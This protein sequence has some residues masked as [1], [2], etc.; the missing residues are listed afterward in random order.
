MPTFLWKWKGNGGAFFG[1]GGKH[2][3]YFFELP[4]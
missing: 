4:F 2:F 1:F 3:N